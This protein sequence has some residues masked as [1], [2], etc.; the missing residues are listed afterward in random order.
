MINTIHLNFAKFLFIRK[1][2]GCG[3]LQF[4]SKEEAERAIREMNGSILSGSPLF[5]RKDVQERRTESVKVI[6]TIA[7]ER[8]KQ[9]RKPSLKSKEEHINERWQKRVEKDKQIIDK[10]LLSKDDFLKTPYS[11][12]QSCETEFHHLISENPEDDRQKML[13]KIEQLIKQREEYRKEKK[14]EEADKIRSMMLKE[15]RVQC[16]DSKRMWRILSR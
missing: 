14:F 5:V 7:R 2:K 10:V 3:L 12:D 8:T 4:D 1:S 15:F 13:L 16:D 11:F 9:L 6:T